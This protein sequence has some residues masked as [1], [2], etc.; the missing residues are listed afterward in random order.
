MKFER[1]NIKHPLWRKKVDS[2]IFKYDATTMPN[3]ICRAWGIDT[4][5]K[6]VTSKNHSK[7]PI[8]IT[9][10]NKIWNGWVTE[11]GKGRVN[12][13]YRLWFEEDLTYELKQVFL[14]SYMRDIES[15]IRGKEDGKQR[16]TTIE[17]DIPFWEF[18][19]IEFNKKS[20][21]FIFVA[22]YTQK[23][24]FPNLFQSITSSPKIKE[25]DQ[26]ISGKDGPK[27]YKQDW[28]PIDEYQTEIGAENIIYMLINKTNKTFY[29]GEAKNLIQRFSSGKYT[30]KWE[31]YRYD[32]L[33]NELEG[34][35]LELERTLIKSFASLLN[36]KK[37]IKTINLSNYTLTNTKIDKN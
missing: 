29:I 6:G 37:D 8:K 27:I 19:D 7:S 9:F 28:K 36:N 3:W 24:T 4:M 17:N 26:K 34:Y 10:N 30:N 2:S 32:K 5:F 15:N 14:M 1:T 25:I 35:R 31:Y 18:L 16:K 21:A 33:P 20:K 11:A 23:P 13:A 22:H 12:P